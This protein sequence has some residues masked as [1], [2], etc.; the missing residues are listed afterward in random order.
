M[1]STTRTSTPFPATSI[2]SPPLLLLM[3]PLLAWKTQAFLPAPARS[4]PRVPHTI[5]TLCSRRVVGSRISGHYATTRDT[6]EVVS[7]VAEVWEGFPEEDHDRFLA[8]FW[9]KKPLLIR[10]AVK[11]FE[12]ILSRDELAGIACLPDAESRLVAGGRRVDEGG[13]DWEVE[14]GPF[15]EEA[16]SEIGETHWTLLV[17][18]V[19]RHVPEVSDLLSNFRFV[20][21]WRVD[22]VMVSYAPERG[23]VGPHVDNYDVF[24]LQGAGKRRWAIEET[25]TSSEEE[26]ARSIEGIDLRVLSDFKEAQAWVLEPGDALYIPPRIAHHGVSL[27]E[28]QRAANSGP[29]A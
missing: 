19:N 28:T 3:S 17:N 25:L 15:E 29:H 10:Q 16:F 9:Q 1:S 13:D 26:A 20:P 22:D 27:D 12:S 5:G 6:A 21:T 11:G 8:E 18:E 4:G 7:V 2:R 14:H 23:S 24:L